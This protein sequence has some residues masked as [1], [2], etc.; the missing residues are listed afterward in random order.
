[1]YEASLDSFT[2]SFEKLLAQYTKEYEHY[3]IDEIVV[4]AIAPIVS[5]VAP[6]LVPRL[7]TLQFRRM[8]NSWDPLEDP[9]AFTSTFWMWR[10]L[11]RMSAEPAP[12]Q[13]VDLYGTRTVPS[14][15]PV[16]VAL[17]SR[18]HRID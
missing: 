11:L 18:P 9:S 17:T 13:Q 6:G 12:Q 3:H 1:M 10:G 2:P 5:A 4:A 14:A 16:Y 15:P 8:L 7:T